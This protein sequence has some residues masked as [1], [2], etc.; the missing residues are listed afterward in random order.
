MKPT[1]QPKP[2]KLKKKTYEGGKTAL[3]NHTFSKQSKKR[4]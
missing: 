2:A 1:Y 4:S 3:K